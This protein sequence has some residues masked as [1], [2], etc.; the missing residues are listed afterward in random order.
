MRNLVKLN[1][2]LWS[3]TLS[4][5]LALLAAGAFGLPQ[6]SAARSADGMT[7]AQM[8]QMGRQESTAQPKIVILMHRHVV[9]LTISNFA[10]SPANVVVSPGTTLI[11]TNKDSDPHTVDSTKNIWSSD[12]L[13]TGNH[14]SRVFGKAGTFTYYCSIHPFMHGKVIVKK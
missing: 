12:A 13:D 8:A 3:L 7:A 1:V 4:G 5:L 11:W 14:F 9:R 2:G 6:H 10:F